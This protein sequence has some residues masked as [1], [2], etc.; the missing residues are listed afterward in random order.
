MVKMI[1]TT[2]VEAWTETLHIRY[3]MTIAEVSLWSDVAE[4]KLRTTGRYGKEAISN[5]NIRNDCLRN[6]RSRIK[7]A[8]LRCQAQGSVETRT[9]RLLPGLLAMTDERSMT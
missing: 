1:C 4:G 8:K 7:I 3:P 2:A 6:K 5:G 9:K